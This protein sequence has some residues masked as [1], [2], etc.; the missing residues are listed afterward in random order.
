M[1]ND[2]LRDR[3]ILQDTS[4]AG[5]RAN[6]YDCIYHRGCIDSVGS[7]DGM[8]LR[9]MATQNVNNCNFTLFQKPGQGGAQF[10]GDGNE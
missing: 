5:C 8:V 7:L 1:A 9:L 6:Y 3:G 2:V 10:R 4:P